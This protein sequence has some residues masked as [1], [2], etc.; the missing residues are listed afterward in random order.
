MARSLTTAAAGLSLA[1]AIAL[2]GAAVE[3]GSPSLALVLFIAAVA[4]AMN[5]TALLLAMGWREI[6]AAR[7]AALAARGAVRLTRLERVPGPSSHWRPGGDAVE[8]AGRAGAALGTIALIGR[9]AGRPRP[10]LDRLNRVAVTRE[11]IGRMAEW[12]VPLT[13]LGAGWGS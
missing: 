2:V 8:L 12:R 9:S 7:R 6:A 11:L 5:V 4:A 10:V 1:V 13:D 3:Y